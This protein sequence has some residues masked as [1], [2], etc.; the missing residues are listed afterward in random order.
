MCVLVQKD[1]FSARLCHNATTK[2]EPTCL[3]CIQI[4]LSLLLNQTC[5]ENNN[6]TNLPKHNTDI[7]MICNLM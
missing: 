4:S 7:C 3:F 6:K 2:V 5:P 1:A